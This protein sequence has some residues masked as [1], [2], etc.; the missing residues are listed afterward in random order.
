MKRKFAIVALI[1]GLLAATPLLAGCT[2]TPAADGI[3]LHY[4]GGTFDGNHF[5]R[6]IGPGESSSNWTISDNDY[7]L[8][9]NVRTWKYCGEGADDKNPIIVNT[10]AKEGDPSG[11]P[12]AVCSVTNMKLNTYDNDI[13]G[14]QGGTVRK[15]WENIGARYKA[16]ETDGWKDMMEHSIVP[17]LAKKLQDVI[18]D[19]DPDQLVGNAN[20]VWT[21]VQN[22]VTS[23]VAGELIRLNGGNYFCGPDFDRGDQT[24]KCSPLA[25]IISNIDFANPNIQSARDEKRAAVERAAAAK[26]QADGEAAKKAALN[27]IYNDPNYLKYLQIQA[28]LEAAKAC[29]AGPH[30]VLVTGNGNTTVQV[31]N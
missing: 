13:P 21:E 8:P 10:K 18:R 31:P 9:I 26:A 19:Y 22:K 14:Y 7:E 29:A 20:S 17:V 24:H 25:M 11:T 2:I 6:V 4:K 23:E 28:N 27:N 15:F 12:V 30:C 5:D 3:T 16:N 1:L